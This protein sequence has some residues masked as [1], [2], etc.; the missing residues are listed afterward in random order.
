MEDL[1]TLFTTATPCSKEYL[2]EKILDFMLSGKTV[3]K[4]SPG[5]AK[6]CSA[7]FLDE[8]GTNSPASTVK[9][10]ACKALH[11]LYCTFRFAVLKIQN[12]Y[13]VFTSSEPWWVLVCSTHGLSLME[14]DCDEWKVTSRL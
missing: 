9:S 10:F 2:Q 1:V 12:I 5:N 14:V 3:N 13:Q 7:I 6:V 4:C 11:R 8:N